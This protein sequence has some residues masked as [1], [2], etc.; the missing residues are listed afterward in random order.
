MSDNSY[1]RCRYIP[2][3]GIQCET[4]F[5]RDPENNPSYLCPLHINQISPKLA[6]QDENKT[7][8]LEI[9]NKEAQS[10]YAMTLT[11]LDAHINGLERILEEQKAKVHAA[12]AVRVDKI[13]KLTEEERD[14]R[15]KIRTERNE[16]SLKPKKA[17]IKTDPIRYMMQTHNLSE[18]AAKKLLG[19]E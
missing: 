3:S 17:T 6:A 8:Y 5:R 15:R 10:C 11:E 16:S 14:V 9:R 7:P 2:D 19:M 13:D 4:W 18:A 12:R 1:T